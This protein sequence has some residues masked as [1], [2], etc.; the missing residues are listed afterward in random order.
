MSRKNAADAFYSGSPG[1]ASLSYSPVKSLGDAGDRIV[2]TQRRRLAEEGMS[3]TPVKQNDFL[4]NVVPPF[5]AAPKF[6]GPA[7]TTANK[8]YG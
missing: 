4:K 6:G 2:R 3:V 1:G 7:F 8:D 5:A